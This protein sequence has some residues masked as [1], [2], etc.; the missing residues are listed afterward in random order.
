[1]PLYIDSL[2]LISLNLQRIANGERVSVIP[3]GSL[4]STQ[5][6]A[7]NAYRAQESLPILQDPEI[8]FLGRHL[9]ASR[10]GDGYSIEDMLTQI[11]SALHAE[12]EFVP[13]RKM[14]ALRNPRARED[15]YG[16]HV[17]DLAVLELSARRPKAELFS[18]IPRGDHIKPPETSK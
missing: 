5:W 11:A 16:N 17:H 15:G 1:M 7:I 2:S 4:T 18:T 12:S 10:R 3:I 6:Q 9:H 13:T 14:T 8:L